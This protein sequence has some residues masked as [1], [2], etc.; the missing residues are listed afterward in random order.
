MGSWSILDKVFSGMLGLL[1]LVV[2]YLTLQ[3]SKLGQYTRVDLCDRVREEN[4][5]KLSR[6][7]ELM[8]GVYKR[9]DEHGKILAK[10]EAIMSILKD[11]V[12]DKHSFDN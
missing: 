5:R 11:K 12:I 4:T 10:V 2:S 3:M 9:L 1:V 7:E 8:D 6:Y